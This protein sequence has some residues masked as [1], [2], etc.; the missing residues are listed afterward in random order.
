MENPRA[1]L[2]LI[3]PRDYGEYRV[4]LQYERTDRHGPAFEALRRDV[5]TVAALQGMQDVFRLRAADVYRI[6]HIEHVRAGTADDVHARV[7]GY[8]HRR[9]GRDRRAQHAVGPGA[10]PRHAR[11][12]RPAWP[13]R[14]ARLR[15][16]DPHARRRDR[17]PP[18]HDREPRVRVG[19]RR[20]GGR[21]GRGDHRR[22]RRPVSGRAGVERHPGP[23]VRPGGAAELRGGGRF[24]GPAPRSRCRVSSWRSHSSPCPRWRWDGSSAC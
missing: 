10:G 7:R 12:H 5:D 4:T 2:L 15:A 6:L 11:R 16:L 14:A 17:H 24:V 8:R 22:R 20:F 18:L 13:R 1:S 21:G 19:G 3:D 23:Q 9:P